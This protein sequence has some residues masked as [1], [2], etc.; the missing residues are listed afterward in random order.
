MTELGGFRMGPF[1]L[2]DLILDINYAVTESVWRAFH[3]PR[4]ARIAQKRNVDAGWLGRKSG[5]G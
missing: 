3:D 2:M 1:Q 5:R 4:F